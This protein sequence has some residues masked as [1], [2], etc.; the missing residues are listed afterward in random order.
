MACAAWWACGFAWAVARER[1]RALRREKELLL[2]L[3]DLVAENYR[4]RAIRG[5]VEHPSR[6]N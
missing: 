3:R 4:L 2:L 5:A 6:T 1:R